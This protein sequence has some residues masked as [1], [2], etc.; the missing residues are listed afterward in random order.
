[1]NR[2]KHVCPPV[3]PCNICGKHLPGHKKQ[4]G[5]FKFGGNIATSSCT[6]VIIE[7]GSNR[8]KDMFV[9]SRK[10]RIH[11]FFKSNK[12]LVFYP[13]F[14]NT[15]ASKSTKILISMDDA[16]VSARKWEKLIKI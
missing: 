11:L 12:I 5:D 16:I 9:V 13:L 10:L 3:R 7:N 1:M 6:R 2:F 8:L 4:A 14:T 15:T